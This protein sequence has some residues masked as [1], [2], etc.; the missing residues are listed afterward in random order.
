MHH[1]AVRVLAIPLLCLVLT[2]CGGDD[3][4]DTDDASTA[5]PAPTRGSVTAT[6]TPESEPEPEPVTVVRSGVLADIPLDTESTSYV[7][8]AELVAADGERLPWAELPGAG[9]H[10]GA[11]EFRGGWLVTRHPSSSDDGLGG[12]PGDAVIEKLDGE[13]R[14]LA[15]HVGSAQ[16]A[17]SADGSQVAWWERIDGVS[18]VLHLES[19]LLR[20]GGGPDEAHATSSG[21]VVPLR[22]LDDGRVAIS[23]TEGRARVLPG[24]ETLRGLWYVHGVSPT[25]HI[26]GVRRAVVPGEYGALVDGFSGEVLWTS[27]RWGLFDF[28]ADGR[29]VL[30]QDS[31]TGGDAGAV[32]TLDARTGAEVAVCDLLSPRRSIGYDPITAR[33]NDDGTV[34]F[35]AYELTRRHGLEAT[36]LR[37]SADG[38]LTRL[39]PVILVA[40]RDDNVRLALVR[41]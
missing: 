7:L 24:L 34:D 5:A 16:L 29:Y 31:V 33:V 22:I 1:S 27:D 17:L 23:L 40:G 10:L 25:G 2:A 11:V 6:P 36:L 14:V 15:Q 30:G 18:G 37:C 9:A 39:S 41:P 3:V 35:V 26:A 8:G 32:A 19:T 28:S 12:R 21:T 4:D 13:G 20:G 38:R